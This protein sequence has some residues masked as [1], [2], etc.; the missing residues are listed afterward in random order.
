MIMDSRIASLKEIVGKKNLREIDK[1]IATILDSEDPSL[2]SQLF[3]LFDDGLKD[4]Q[5]MFSVI[6]AVESLE[7]SYYLKTF[8]QHLDRLMK[9]APESA[10]YLLLRIANHLP[11]F[12]MLKEELRKNPA[13][14]K[15]INDAKERVLKMKPDSRLLEI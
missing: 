10:A 9:V 6:H 1:G 8:L 13:S 4:D 11:S 7:N 2:I 14:I 3:Y 12:T 15:A 5:I